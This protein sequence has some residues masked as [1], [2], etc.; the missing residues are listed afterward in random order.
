MKIK[1][2]IIHR[3]VKGQDLNH[4]GTLFAGRIAE[5]FVEAG[6]IAAASCTSPESVVCANIHGMVFS[7]PVRAGDILRF[8]SRVVLSGRS[9]LVTYVSIAFERNDEMMLDGFLTFVHVDKDGRPLPHGIVIDAVDP[10]DIRLQ[11]RARSLRPG[12][13]PQG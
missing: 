12:T 1:S 4:H 6:L 8:D 9:R 2:Y 7:K 3:H 10:E 13:S 5:W 11:D